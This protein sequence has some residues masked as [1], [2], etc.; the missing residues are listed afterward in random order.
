M[1]SK[2]LCSVLPGIGECFFEATGE[3]KPNSFLTISK[4]TRVVVTP[5]GQIGFQKLIV[6]QL[7]MAAPV[8]KVSTAAIVIMEPTPEGLSAIKRVW[9]ENGNIVLPNPEEKR[10]I[11]GQ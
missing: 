3:L 6:Q 2:W 7:K 5:Q 9:S 10:R 8:A 4:V 1:K 11:I